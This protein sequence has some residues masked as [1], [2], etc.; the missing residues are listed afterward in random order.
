VVDLFLS[1]SRSIEALSVAD[2][3]VVSDQIVQALQ[4]AAAIIGRADPGLD[5]P[6]SE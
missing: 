6:E 4:V 1:K 3:T 5:A 2:A